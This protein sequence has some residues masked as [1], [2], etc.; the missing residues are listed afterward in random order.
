[1]SEGHLNSSDRNAVVSVDTGMDTRDLLLDQ[2]FLQRKRPADHVNR[3]FEAL[4]R[5]AHVFAE[6]PDAI[7]QKLVDIAVE[8]CGA[9]SSGISLEEPDQ[10]GNLRF[11]WI[12]VAG[13][14]SPYLNG[15]TPRLYS[16]CGTCLDRKQPQH[17]RVTKPYY[18]FLGVVAEP[19]HD[20]ILIPWISDTT[21]GTL[22]AV[23]HKSEPAFYLEDY[24]L[25]NSLADFASIA[26]RHK[27]QATA[28][29]FMD[30][31]HAS[32]AKAN[33]LAHQI[34]NPLQ[35]L[36]NLLYLATQ[37]AAEAQPL[38]RRALEEVKALSTLV[39]SILNLRLPP[40]T[41]S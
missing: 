25:L 11:R 24:L 36:T 32:A 19:I 38:A 28:L 40:G 27:R 22:W 5:L 21:R 33:E 35:S 3:H 16:P 14:F 23:S 2:E 15:T 6:E 31:E 30:Q 34:N 29:R 20:G 18:D 1:L 12:V 13:S 10:A 9:D 39:K 4:H 8:F 37:N 26:V 17:Y 41:K 7:L